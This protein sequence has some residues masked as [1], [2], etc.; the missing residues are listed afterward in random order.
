MYKDDILIAS[1]MKIN[2]DKSITFYC[3]VL[4]NTFVQVLR[5]ADPVKKIKETIASLSFK[6]EFTY[7]VNCILRSSKFNREGLWNKIDKEL[8]NIC[9]NTTGYISYGEQFH[10]HHVNQTMVMLA[11]E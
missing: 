3:Q 11:V 8:I 10:K 9:N 1:P 7:V 4:P 6:P 2:D 5:P